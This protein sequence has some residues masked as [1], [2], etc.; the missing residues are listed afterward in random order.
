MPKLVYLGPYL[1]AM[2]EDV[3]FRHGQPQV[4][5]FEKARRILTKPGFYDTDLAI[6][7]PGGTGAKLFTTSRGAWDDTPL[8]SLEV[9]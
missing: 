2:E 4:V 1:E 9:V 3:R 8:P 7:V 6:P 5:G